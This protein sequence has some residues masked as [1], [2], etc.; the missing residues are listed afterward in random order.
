MF[1]YAWNFDR[2]GYAQIKDNDKLGFID[3][4]GAVVADP[5]F[6]AVKE[7]YWQNCPV[8]HWFADYRYLYRLHCN[9]HSVSGFWRF[10]PV[11]HQS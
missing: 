11:G 1:D 10:Q 5:I 7:E 2:Y 9:A 8:A 4:L 3:T 6:D